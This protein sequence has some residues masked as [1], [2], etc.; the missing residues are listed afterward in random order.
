M[1]MV[2]STAKSHNILYIVCTTLL[3]RLS[4]KIQENFAKQHVYESL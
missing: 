3:I 4:I 2:L 1:T